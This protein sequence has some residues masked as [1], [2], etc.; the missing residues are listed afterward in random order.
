MEVGE[1]HQPELYGIGDGRWAEK[2]EL[3]SREMEER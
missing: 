3:G 1:D 2:A